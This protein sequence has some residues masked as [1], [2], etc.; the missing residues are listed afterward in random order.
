MKHLSFVVFRSNPVRLK[1]PEGT[2]LERQF[3]W[4]SHLLK[5]NTSSQ[6]YPKPGWKSGVSCKGTRVLDCETDR[7][8]RCES[9]S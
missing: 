6:R 9:R 5:G 3:D 7:S 8:S 4:G 2:V 1:P